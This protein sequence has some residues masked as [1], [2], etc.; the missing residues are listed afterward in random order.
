MSTK[1]IKP[2]EI[3]TVHLDV[4]KAFLRSEFNA[5]IVANPTQ[6]R[7]DYH[8]FAKPT[9]YTAQEVESVARDLALELAQAGYLAGIGGGD[10]NLITGYYEIYIQLG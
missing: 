6:K 2:S 8:K 4:L 5:A 3:A 7:F 9:E 1:F 10:L